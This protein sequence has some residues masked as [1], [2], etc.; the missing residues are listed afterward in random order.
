MAGKKKAG[1]LRYV[2]EAFTYRWNL[3]FLGGAAAAAVIS[4]HPDV[5]LPLVAAG[6]IAYLA[7]L[8][9]LP[10][11]QAAID[12]KARGTQ[13]SVAAAVTGGSGGTARQKL[14][15][16][17]G[18]LEPDRRNRFLRLRAR[19]V[20]MQRIANAVRG[21]TSDPS[22]AAAELRTPALDRL[23]WVFLKLLLS[24][25]ALGR[26]LR[27]ADGAGIGK[28]LD[29]LVAR[30]KEAEAKGDDR[31]LRSLTD[32]V[33][34]AQ[35][36]LDNYNKA[37]NN[38]EFVTVELD[39]IESKIQALTEMAIS[40][41]NPDELSIQVDAVAAG[42]SQTEETIRELQAITGLGDQQEAPSILATDVN[43]VAQ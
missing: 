40:H 11:F 12:A 26:F 29:E 14:A 15:D 37:K 27:A 39:R 36:R 8:T 42:M 10:R 22:G 7:G 6:E 1:W 25:Q 5:A 31:I 19:C 41:Q 34:T 30:Q 33:A 4:G 9:T 38:A 3:L 20:E 24:Q 23:L 2:K 17:L 21:D 32:S 18:S 43:E 13:G 35:L 16:V 28:Q